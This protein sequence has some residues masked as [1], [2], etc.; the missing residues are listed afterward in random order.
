M[1]PDSHQQS[2]WRL[3]VS[4]TMSIE[5]PAHPTSKQI[6]KLGQQWKLHT[7]TL[8]KMIIQHR[9]SWVERTFT[10]AS[11]IPSTILFTISLNIH[12]S[13]PSIKPSIIPST[14]LSDI[15]RCIC[16]CLNVC[17][18]VVSVKSNDTEKLHHF[19][20]I[21][22]CKYAE[23]AVCCCSKNI[24][25]HRVTPSACRLTVPYCCSDSLNRGD[26]PEV[27]PVTSIHA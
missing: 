16:S 2:S 20:A 11:T 14:I 25:W 26:R 22:R 1:D 6:A 3:Q 13:I 12:S 19:P 5:H 27:K 21:G 7:G 4:G 18:T 8:F 23:I 15:T 17:P 24:H 10:I 9:D